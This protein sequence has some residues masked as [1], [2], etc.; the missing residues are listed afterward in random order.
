MKKLFLFLSVI[1]FGLTLSSCLGSGNSNFTE[2]SIVYIKQYNGIVY[3]RTLS[4]NAITS[5]KIKMMQ[6][7]T[8]KAFTYTWDEEYGFAD[9]GSENARIYNVVIL[10]DAQDI[11][12]RALTLQPVS[13]NQ[14]AA[15]KQI[16][17]IQYDTNGAYLDDYMLFNYA[18]EHKEGEK[19]DISFHL[20]ATEQESPETLTVD[21][22]FNLVE[23][24]KENA[25]EETTVD[26]IAVNM[27]YIRDNFLENKN[28]EVKIEFLYYNK[29]GEDSNPVK[30]QNAF[31]SST[32][33]K[34]INSGDNNQ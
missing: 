34:M 7:G 26:I 8:F 30:V 32:E 24:A 31:T 6:P 10:G 16:A 20:R 29:I 13:E 18:L 1:T 21:I 4:G 2:S 14:G 9:T 17:G 5:A 23:E 33:F 22:R 12:N 11:D 15:I 27:K 19:F 25:K 28:S 3:G